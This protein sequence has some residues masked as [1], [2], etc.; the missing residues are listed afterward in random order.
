MWIMIA[1]PYLSG[2]KSEA[3]R[4]QNLLR[5]NSAAAEVFRRGHVPIVGVNLALPI[6]GALGPYQVDERRLD[7]RLTADCFDSAGVDGGF[8]LWSAGFG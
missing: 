7:W 3:E 6:I 5:L 1:G 2:A 8:S 4:E